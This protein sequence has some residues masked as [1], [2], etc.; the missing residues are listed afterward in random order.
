PIRKAVA[1]R[2]ARSAAIQS[3]GRAALVSGSGDLIA[4]GAA[5]ALG[6]LLSASGL[7]FST[8][9]AIVANYQKCCCDNIRDDRKALQSV[10]AKSPCSLPQERPSPP[11][12]PIAVSGS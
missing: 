1:K 10:D 7:A 6:H 2:Y 5:T 12:C 4:G 3:T 9:I 8:I 11:C